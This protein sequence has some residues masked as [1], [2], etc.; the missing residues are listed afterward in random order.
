MFPATAFWPPYIFIPRN[1][2]LLSLPFL[3]LPTPFL[4]DIL[5]PPDYLKTVLKIKFDKK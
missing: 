4:L 3:E 1:W 2:G 5:N